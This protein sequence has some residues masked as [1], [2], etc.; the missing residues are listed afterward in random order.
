MLRV[1]GVMARAK[2]S[3]DGSS[4]WSGTLTVTIEDNQPPDNPAVPSGPISGR[5][6][7]SYRYS[8]SAVDLD[9]DKVKLAFNWGDGTTLETAFVDSGAT[10]GAAH[11]WKKVGT[12][13][14]KARAIDDK[15][16]TSGWS[17]GLAVKISYKSGTT[18]P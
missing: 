4:P 5:P 17:S 11:I 14:V 10:V 16:T 1:A 8:T 9:G 6:R 2:D 18:A 12:Y 13:Y 3:K 7:I 15:G